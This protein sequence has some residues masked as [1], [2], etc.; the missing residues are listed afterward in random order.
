MARDALAMPTCSKLSS[1]QT[2][3]VRS[4]IRGKQSMVQA[5]EEEEDT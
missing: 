5:F 4:I 2:A 3:H 1:E